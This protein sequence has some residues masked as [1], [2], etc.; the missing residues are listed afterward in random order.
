MP[1]RS[2]SRIDSTIVYLLFAAFRA[3]GV[4]HQLHSFEPLSLQP[5]RKLLHP[6]LNDPYHDF[7]S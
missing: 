5:H 6:S 7:P 3:R 4:G 1:L 2:W